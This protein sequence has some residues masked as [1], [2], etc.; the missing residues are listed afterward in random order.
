LAEVSLPGA[1]IQWVGGGADV[2]P[3]SPAAGK[4]R[5]DGKISAYICMGERCSP[6]LTDPDS[7][8]DRLK[9][10]RHVSVQVAASSV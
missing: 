3:S 7:V 1:V 10:E 9:E 8:K 2:P 5:A 4:G 6:P